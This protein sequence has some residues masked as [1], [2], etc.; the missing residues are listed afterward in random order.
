MDIGKRIK[1]LREAKGWTTNHLA[2]RC[3]ISQSFLRSVERNEKGI[4]VANL[5]LI[6]AELGLSMKA[7]FDVPSEAGGANDDLLRQVE[8]LT[9]EQRKALAAFLDAMTRHSYT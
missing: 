3:S 7:F 5:S 6:C 9:S 2:N 4:S 8:H 1:Q